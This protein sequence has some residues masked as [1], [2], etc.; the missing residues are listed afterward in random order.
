MDSQK[1]ITRFAPSPTGFMHVGGVRTALFSYLF[2][3]KNNG[4]FI[5]RI[6][7][8]DKAREVAGSMEHIIESL[9]WL[10]INHDQGP[11]IGGPNA[12]Y[13]QSERLESYKKYAQKLVDTGYAYVDPYTEEEIE[14]LRQDAEDKKQP[15][16]Y[17]EHRKDDNNIV[18][19]GLNQTLRFKVKV[20]KRY[21]WN[22][23]V[24]GKL[25]AGVEALDDFVL[26]K[27]DGYPTYNFAHVIDDI[28]MKITHVMRGQEFVSSTPKFLALY[29]ALEFDAPIFVSLPHIIGDNGGKKLGKRDGSKNILD[30]RNDGY[31]AQAMFNFLAFLGWNPGTDQEIMS[32]DEIVQAFDITKLQ[33]GGAQ[34]ND[35]KLNWFNREHIKRLS[36]DE[37]TKLILEF[38]PER[39]KNYERCTDEYIKKLTPIIVDHISVFGEVTMLGEMGEWDYFFIKPIYDEKML[40]SP[41]TKLGSNAQDRVFDYIKNILSILK[42]IPEN[43]WDLDNIKMK[44]MDYADK[45]GKGDVLWAFR[46]FLTG[47]EKSPDPFTVVNILGKDFLGL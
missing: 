12:P 35:I 17:R 1:I 3:K 45:N 13:L 16:L 40:V 32:H 10:G 18:W 33:K 15:F 23:V 9:K 43:E 27:S 34:F 44:V 28:E 42:N 46:V 29:E 30:Y 25:S 5:L 26:I 19:T 39:I 4:T 36:L 20:I 14:K 47:K 24:F 38:L 8:T 31:L 2:S 11:D 7:D 21:E 22:D 37:Q 41:K 6:E